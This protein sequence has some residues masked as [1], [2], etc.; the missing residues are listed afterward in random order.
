MLLAQPKGRPSPNLH[1]RMIQG[2]H[3]WGHS[4]FTEATQ[5][6]GSFLAHRPLH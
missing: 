4:R 5:F 3:Q 1:I 6:I 2:R